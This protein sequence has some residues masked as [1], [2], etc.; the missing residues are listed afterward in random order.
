MDKQERVRTIVA[1][2]ACF[3]G[4]VEIGYIGKDGGAML[5]HHNGRFF[6]IVQPGH[7]GYELFSFPSKPIPDPDPTCEVE[8]LGDAVDRWLE[9]VEKLEEILK[10]NPVSGY[11]FVRDC[12][13]GRGGW[14]TDHQI[15]DC[16]LFETF[17]LDYC[18]LLIEEYEAK[19]NIIL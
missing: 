11:W 9:D 4:V 14:L 3:E 5:A 12:M 19:H 16:K 18:G 2:E 7:K 8:E 15:N 10:M 13:E 1:C 17:L 6:V